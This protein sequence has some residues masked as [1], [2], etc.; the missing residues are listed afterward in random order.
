[1]STP[2]EIADAWNLVNQCLAAGRGKTQ[3][4]F[5]EEGLVR[6]ADLLRRLENTPVVDL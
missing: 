1:M 4:E 6:L 3:Q 5:A 2:Q